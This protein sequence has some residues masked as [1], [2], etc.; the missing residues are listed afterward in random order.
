MPGP[1][2]LAVWQ[3]DDAEPGQIRISFERPWN[4]NHTARKARA[5][6][7]LRN[8]QRADWRCRGCGDP[9]GRHK[10][11]DAVFCSEGCRKRAAR[12]RRQYR[13]SR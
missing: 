6:A 8:L 10:R 1:D 9:V 4:G 7:I 3:D 5:I 13:G 11:A 12:R 2:P